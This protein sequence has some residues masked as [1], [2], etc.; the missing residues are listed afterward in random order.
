MAQPFPNNILGETAPG[1]TEMFPKL[2]AL[3]QGKAQQ[4]KSEAG[5]ADNSSTTSNSS[6]GENAAFADTLGGKPFC[7]NRLRLS[8][9]RIYINLH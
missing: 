9:I 7:R 2:L 4:G 8:L 6:Q 3:H 5:G 1:M